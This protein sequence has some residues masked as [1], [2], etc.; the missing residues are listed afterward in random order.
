MPGE[1]VFRRMPAKARPAKHL[2]GEPSSGP[3]VVMGQGTF[4]SVRLKD[5]ATG[6]L[7]DGGVNIPLEQILAGPR[8]S[9]L[10]FERSSDV[11]SVG[12][13]LAGENNAG[14]LPPEVRARGWKPGQK[15]GWKVW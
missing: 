8:R 4:S 15:R 5:P 6:Q 11:R 7:V 2:L 12:Q 9:L 3:Y 1:I 14:T 10:E 13:M